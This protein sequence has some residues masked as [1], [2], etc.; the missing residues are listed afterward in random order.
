MAQ[1]PND[2]LSVGERLEHLH[3]SPLAWGVVVFVCGGFIVAGFGLI[4]ATPWLFYVGIAV[5]VVASLVGWLTHS[6][7]AATTR[8]KPIHNA[9]QLASSG[10]DS[11]D[12]DR[13]RK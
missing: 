8:V 11:A 6:V 9:A 4:G 5:V 3:G 10:G 12:R 13:A 2:D 1:D 7:S